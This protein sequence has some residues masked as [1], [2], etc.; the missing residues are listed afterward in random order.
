MATIAALVSYSHMR[1]LALANGR[2][3]TLAALLPLSADGLVAVAALAMSADRAEGRRRRGWAL[4]GF[5]LGLAASLAATWTA[6]MGGVTAHL[7]PAWAPLALLVTTEILAKPG[8][9]ILPDPAGIEPVPVAP[10]APAQPEPAPVTPRRREPATRSRPRSLTAEAK[11]RQ[12]AARMP[13]ATT[14]E[15]AARASV[16]EST[17]R[18]YRTPLAPPSTQLPA[19]IHRVN[20]HV[21]AGAKRLNERGHLPKVPP[22]TFTAGV[23]GCRRQ[24]GQRT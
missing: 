16:S 11:V 9:P 22:L 8:K 19:D 2:P 15:I 13:G 18:R 5:W 1:T 21:P 14:A 23:T 10:E 3:T 4:V 24:S 6:T 17:V 12:A 7:V 20:G